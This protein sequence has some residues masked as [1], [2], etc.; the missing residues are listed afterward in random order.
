MSVPV[1]DS[2]SSYPNCPLHVLREK[3]V[4]Q[5]RQFGQLP[6]RVETIAI[7]D[8]RLLQLNLFPTD[9]PQRQPDKRAVDEM[10]TVPNVPRTGWACFFVLLCYAAT[11]VAAA[12]V[13]ESIE[14]S[15]AIFTVWEST[16]YVTVSLV[17]I[18]V[19]F[20]MTSGL[21]W[22]GTRIEP[23]WS[24]YAARLVV[25][26]AATKLTNW[27]GS[28]DWVRNASYLTGLTLAQCT[29]F[30]IAKVPAWRSAKEDRRE[31]S[32]ERHQFQISDLIAA[33]T[34]CAGLLSAIRYYETPIGAS[35]YWLVTLMIWLVGPW[36]A[37]AVHRCVLQRRGWRRLPMF[38]AAVVTAMLA[39]AGLSYAQIAVDKMQLSVT[40]ILPFYAAFMI[41]YVVTLFV[42]S[43]AGKIQ[44]L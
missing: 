44:R 1:A 42:F 43:I 29:V 17:Q 9:P 30:V 32:T 35:E 21:V 15:K 3:L 39:T 20:G 12:L 5:F 37:V 16:L 7:E 2:C 36:I 25:V 40:Q 24:R 23:R 18:G 28:D 41:G 10:T 27:I 31:A 14:K 26:A 34:C 6:Y 13:I 8:G 19:V 33:T 22:M 38:M 11:V 4:G